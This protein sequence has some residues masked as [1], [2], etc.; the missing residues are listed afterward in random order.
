MTP[1][2]GL[3][4]EL[5]VLPKC[6]SRGGS[7][8]GQRDCGVVRQ[9]RRHTRDDWHQDE[10]EALDSCAINSEKAVRI[11]YVKQDAELDG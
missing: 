10:P 8:S 6:L 7:E 9:L 11:V 1:E 4:L 2:R 5:G 3:N